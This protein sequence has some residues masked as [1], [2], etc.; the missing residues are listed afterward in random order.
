MTLTRRESAMLTGIIL[1]LLVIAFRIVSTASAQP[2][3]HL[4]SFNS[5]EG[6]PVS[7]S[8]D[9]L[10]VHVRIL[11]GGS[12]PALNPFAGPKNGRIVRDGSLIF[13]PHG[14]PVSVVETGYFTLGTSDGNIQIPIT[15]VRLEDGRDA[16]TES[17]YVF[18]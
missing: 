5:L 7:L 17:I 14:T 3:T 1:L 13:L 8:L 4:R 9:T 6:V 12:D 18:P 11:G 16:W 10:S 15:Q 2:T